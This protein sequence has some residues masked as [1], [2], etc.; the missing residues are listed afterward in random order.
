MTFDIDTY[1]E[2]QESRKG[3]IHTFVQTGYVAKLW[4]ESPTA[5]RYAPQWIKTDWTCLFENLKAVDN[6]IN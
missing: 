1:F 6:F 5:T 2:L 3:T 4:F